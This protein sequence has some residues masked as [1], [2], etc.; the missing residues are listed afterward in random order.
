MS[1]ANGN[2]RMGK[3]GTTKETVKEMERGKTRQYRTLGKEENSGEKRFWKAED[4]RAYAP[5]F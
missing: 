1:T 5:I 3:N 2:E 4:G